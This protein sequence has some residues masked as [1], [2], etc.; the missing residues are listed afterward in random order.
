MTEFGNAM[1]EVFAHSRGAL[2]LNH[3]SFGSPPRE[4]IEARRRFEDECESLPDRW[5][6]GGY[7]KIVLESRKLVANYINSDVEDLTFVESSSTAVNSVLRSYKYQPGD[8][9]IVLSTAYPMVKNTLNYLVENH[10]LD[11]VVIVPVVLDG[12]GTSPRGLHGSLLNSIEQAIK[13]TA[14]K[15]T[16][17]IFSHI[18]SCPSIIEPIEQLIPLCKRYGISVLID[19]AH[20]IGHVPVNIKSLEALG[21]DYWTSNGHKWLYCT[22]GASI[23]WVTRNKQPKVI[24][25]VISSSFADIVQDKSEFLARYEY[26]STRDYTSFC[27]YKAAIKFREKIGEEK[28]RKYNHELVVWAQHYLATSWKTEVLVPDDMIG[29]MGNVRL[30]PVIK[31]VKQIEWLQKIL[32]DE[33]ET[34]I[35][36]YSIIHPITKEQTYWAR[37]SAQIYLE[38]SDFIKFDQI[39]K[40]VLTRVPLANL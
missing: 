11:K 25:T 13:E 27:T 19:G 18:T 37:I 35:A 12:K 5:F 33:Y 15:I 10:I 24:P 40:E 39:I 20:T 14:S 7:Q 31:N 17:A 38:K 4:V 9:V 32:L 3:G 29:M 28:I 8:A 34:T 30:P 26:T 23:L 6:R 22:K 2:N 21:M 1:K 16:L 36:L